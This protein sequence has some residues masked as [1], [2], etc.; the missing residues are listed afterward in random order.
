MK[1]KKLIS[2][3]DGYRY[4]RVYLVEDWDKEKELDASKIVYDGY[5]DDLPICWINYKVKAIVPYLRRLPNKSDSEAGVMVII[6]QK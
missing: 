1:L 5:V 3:L 4:T 2:K 6:N